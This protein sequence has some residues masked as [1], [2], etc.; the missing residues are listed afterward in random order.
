MLGDA[1]S[2]CTHRSSGVAV[3]TRSPVLTQ[4]GLCWTQSKADA[5]E[6]PQLTVRSH[7]IQTMRGSGPSAS[8][9][10]TQTTF[11]IVLVQLV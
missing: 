2:C 8:D 11:Q 10:M 6:G 4:R 5:G 9:T 3:D 7:G 1:L